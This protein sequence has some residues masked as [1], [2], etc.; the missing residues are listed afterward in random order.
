MFTH[1]FQTSIT[2][3]A[4]QMTKLHLNVSFSELS[5]LTPIFLLFFSIPYWFKGLRHRKNP[6]IYAL[7]MTIHVSE[8]FD[9]VTS[10]NFPILIWLT[11]PFLCSVLFKLLENHIHHRPL[12]FHCIQFFTLLSKVVTS[13]LFQRPLLSLSIGHCFTNVKVCLFPCL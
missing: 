1:S 6:Q 2:C 4:S 10:R 12:L 8:F 11:A 5:I 13:L 7:M 9:A 3:K